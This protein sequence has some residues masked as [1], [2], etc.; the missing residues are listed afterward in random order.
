[1]PS[2]SPLYRLI[3]L[4]ALAACVYPSP[5]AAQ[6]SGGPYGPIHQV[7]EVPADARHVYYVAPDGNEAAPGK[8]LAAPTTFEKAIRAARTGDAI[9]LRGGTYRTGSILF[10][11]GVT[12][13][14]FRDERPVLVG[15]EV[16]TD[17]ERLQNGLWR[18]A[19]PTLFPAK[20]AEW[21]RR[22]RHGRE[23]PPWAFN[24]DM[25]F[26]GD[27][28]L[29]P[30][31]W[32]GALDAHTYFINYE[33]GHVYIAFDPT[34][35]EMEI[36]AHDGALTRTTEAINGVPSDGKG[37]VIRGLTLTRYAYRALEIEGH[38]P[39]GP[40]DPATFGKDVVGTV[41]E[42]VT[43]T[44]CSRV[45]A[46]LRG[47]N[48][49]V[50]NCLISDTRT[51]GI[52]IFS[53]ADVLLEKN[54]FQRNN[55]DGMT[56]YF[57]SAVKIFNQCYRTVCRDNLVLEN[58]H[59]SGI[60]YDV[61]NV[62]GVFVNNW[63]D[64]ATDGFFF[65][66]SKGATAVGNVF[67]NCEKGIRSL[68]SS[69]VRAWNNTFV[70]SMA[71]YERTTRSAQ[72]DHF[73]WHPATGPDVD[74]RHGHA[75]ENNLLV[76]TPTY[77]RELLNVAQVP[78]LCGVLTDVPLDLLDHNVY[79]RLGPA[80]GPLVHW[81]PVEGADCNAGY[82]TLAAFQAAVPALARNSREWTDYAGPLFQGLHLQRFELLPGFPG[83][84]AGGPVPEAVAGLLGWPADAPHPPGAF[85]VAVASQR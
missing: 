61:G 27:E 62:D 23:T 63:V 48:L 8:D 67:I 69:G 25:V 17:W 41:L 59:S 52:F 40:A 34:G 38:D 42:N 65:E 15:T 64:T 36:T 80:R 12:L 66:I 13:Q 6:P 54:I 35:R 78:E 55:M 77:R 2:M 21:W 26:A 10:N 70:D 50:R 71:S 79:V 16:A 57:P 47:D 32:E 81:S 72:G 85:P 58:P 37:P 11:Q 73:G 82:D 39:E 53:S 49:V 76:A 22:F 74:E 43:I 7:Y 5:A 29:R 30:V 1:M 75:F 19:W 83:V 3:S 24:N 84:T 51:E 56:G 45:G 14:P 33:D 60:W 68:N 4:C 18:T 31:G 44:Y 20:P 28:L 46:Y 9:I